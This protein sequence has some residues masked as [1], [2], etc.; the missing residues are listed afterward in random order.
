MP[1]IGVLES[2]QKPTDKPTRRIKRS[3]GHS[4]VNRGMAVWIR[5]NV[6]LQMRE[7][8]AAPP[9]PITVIEIEHIQ[10]AP[11]LFKRFARWQN[12]MSL[13]IRDWRENLLIHYP[14]ADQRSI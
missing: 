8:M 2:H 3:G 5:E 12:G 10:V 4:L 9:I 1:T 11:K 7:Q 6:L 14:I 13:P